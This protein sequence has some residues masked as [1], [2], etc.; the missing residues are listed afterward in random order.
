MNHRL[1][2]VFCLWTGMAHRASADI[3]PD[4]DFDNDGDVDGADLLTWQRGLGL[5]SGVTHARGDADL[6]GQIN[7]NDFAWWQT[8][9][10]NRAYPVASTVPEPSA[11]VIALCNLAGFAV[12]LRRPAGRRELRDPAT[13]SGVNQ[14]GMRVPRMHARMSRSARPD[15]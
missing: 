9:F 13:T 6:D 1:L 11:G 3:L 2:L 10:G 15:G 12:G 8:Q 5:M 14:I 7:A 4:A